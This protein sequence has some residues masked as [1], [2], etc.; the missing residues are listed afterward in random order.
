MK[1]YV[2]NHITSI[3]HRGYSGKYPDNSYSAFRAAYDR[4]FNMIEL[5]IQA[6]KTGEL[7][8][9]H[10]VMISGIPVCDLSLKQILKKNKNILTLKNFFDNFP[11]HSKE[12]YFDLKGDIKTAYHLFAFL[13]TWDIDI[14]NMIA[15]SF[16]RKHLDLLEQK[17]PNLRRGYITSNILS[18]KML[19][20]LVPHIHF[21]CLEY[22]ALDKEMIEYCKKKGILIFTYTMTNN[23]ELN[24]MQKFRIDGIVT[25]FKLIKFEP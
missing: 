15:C 13:R 21:L 25:N 23:N 22:S 9:Y 16:N 14:S 8:I 2:D 7:I 4:N 20:E 3:A 1:F 18:E 6:C 24:Y 19:K 17:M 12:L 5:D 11:Y 10:D